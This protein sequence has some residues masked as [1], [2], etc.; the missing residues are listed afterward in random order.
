MGPAF[1]VEA[2]YPRTTTDVE[3]ADV[4]PAGFG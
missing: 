4:K 1:A 3:A 2:Q